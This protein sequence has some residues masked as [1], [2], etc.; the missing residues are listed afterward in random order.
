[1]DELEIMLDEIIS[2]M[3]QPKQGIMGKLR[4]L[5]DQAIIKSRFSNIDKAE[6]ANQDYRRILT[7]YLAMH[8]YKWSD[9]LLESTRDTL[10]MTYE[11]CATVD[12]TV[13]AMQAISRFEFTNPPNNKG[14]YTFTQECLSK[15]LTKCHTP[16][17]FHSKLEELQEL[18]EEYEMSHDYRIMIPDLEFT[19]S[20]TL[21]EDSTLKDTL[22]DF[23]RQKDEAW[24]KYEKEYYKIMD[25]YKF[26]APS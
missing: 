7:Q 12:N 6:L 3:D 11:S 21:T 23:Y 20:G 17:D 22:N 19:F 4:N 24:E 25:M 9:G 5:R 13:H 16:E 18:V 15:M 8:G 2:E 14:L 10:A 1:M 26:F